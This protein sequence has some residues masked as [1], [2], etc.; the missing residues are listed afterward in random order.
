MLFLCHS[1]PADVPADAQKWNKA[2]R[3][4]LIKQDEYSIAKISQAHRP[5]GFTN[6]E[7]LYGKLI[8][9]QITPF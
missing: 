2:S 5:D 7:L 8:Y 9:D 3:Q 4:T 1:K 6:G